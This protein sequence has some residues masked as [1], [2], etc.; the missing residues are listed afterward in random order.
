MKLKPLEPGDSVRVS[1]LIDIFD[2]QITAYLD[3]KLI[4][5]P[6]NSEFWFVEYYLD[7]KKYNDHWHESY[8]TSKHYV[9]STDNEL[10]EKAEKVA[11][12]DYVGLLFYDDH[13]FDSA[14]EV[15][16]W[17]EDR[18]EED[19]EPLKFVWACDTAPVKLQLDLESIVSEQLDEDGYEQLAQQS[20]EAKRRDRHNG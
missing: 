13:Y 3:G 11:A 7:G 20:M 5:Q 17:W 15:L 18:A 6:I 9:G 12:K 8:I 2:H 14:D 19:D 4:N 16:E 1:Y 10:F